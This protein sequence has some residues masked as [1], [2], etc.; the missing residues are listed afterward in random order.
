MTRTSTASLKAAL[1]LWFLVSLCGPALAGSVGMG[2]GSGLP[3]PRFVSLRSDEVNLRTGP[4]IQYPVDWTY[5]RRGYPVE[6]IAEYETWRRIRDWEGTEGWVHQSMLAGRR[7]FVVIG[8]ARRLRREPNDEAAPVAVIEPGVVG[9]LAECPKENQF[10]RVEIAPY[11]GWLKRGE[12]WGGIH[13]GE[14]L[15]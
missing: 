3:L 8:Q 14:Y 12:F 11:A 13:R 1:A 15:N 6:V 2:K 4:G 5:L 10:C 7:T 9:H